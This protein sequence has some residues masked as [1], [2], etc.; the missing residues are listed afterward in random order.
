M[1]YFYCKPKPLRPRST[2][3]QHVQKVCR[4]AC[5]IA[6]PSPRYTCLLV[7]I[8]VWAFFNAAAL[9]MP[10]ICISILNTTH[11]FERS[12]RCLRHLTRAQNVVFCSFCYDRFRLFPS[13]AVSLRVT[14]MEFSSESF[15]S[16]K[17]SIC[18]DLLIFCSILQ[19]GK[20]NDGKK[21]EGT[22]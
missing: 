1:Q 5:V 4:Y 18:T 17:H 21:H 22:Q 3:S 7:S 14:R 20:T 15:R 13:L 2:P 19:S 16:H 10:P 11:G 8:P 9:N 12:F 6:R